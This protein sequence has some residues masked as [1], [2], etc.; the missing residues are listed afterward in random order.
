[1]RLSVLSVPEILIKHCTLYNNIVSSQIY[2]YINIYFVPLD[3]D[4]LD[5][6]YLNIHNLPICIE[7]R[8]A[9]EDIFTFI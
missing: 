6:L 3:R 4:V 1:M 2:I 9:S 8:K 7:F 5:V